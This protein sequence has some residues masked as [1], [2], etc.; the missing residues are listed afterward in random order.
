MWR[1][2][3]L[4]VLLGTSHAAEPSC[5]VCS[6]Y[7]YE[8]SL[9]ERVLSNELALKHTLD[10]ISETHA[11]VEDTLKAIQGE[12]VKLNDA[13]TAL[14][15][16]K[17]EMDERLKSSINSGI[18]N[19]S[20]TISEMKTNVQVLVAKTEKELN[21]M[22]EQNVVPLVIFHARLHTDGNKHPLTGNQVIAFKTVLVNEGRGYDPA[23]GNFTASVAGV[24]M[25][26]VQYCPFAAS[27]VSLEITHE[28]KPLQRSYHYEN[29]ADVCVSMQAFAK[30]AMGEKV[31]VRSIFSC[32]LYQEGY[33]W[34]S[35][36][37]FLVHL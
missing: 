18:T 29:Y 6:K 8:V 13:M 12:N 5:P 20:E 23:T 33:K 9:L 10:K 2:L 11:K 28:G 7:A 31:W 15:V 14:E 22:K 37:G 4:L 26:T 19:V 32:D 3:V 1:L 16:K 25:F 36:A 27:S 35:F 34:S 24:Y 30:V 21:A 17:K